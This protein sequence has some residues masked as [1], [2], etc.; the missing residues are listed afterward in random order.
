MSIRESLQ[1]D[2]IRDTL[3]VGFG[4]LVLCLVGA[5]AIGWIAV[6]AGSRDV[7]DELESV[8]SASQQTS[9]YATI[10]TR[11]IQAASSYLANHDSTSLRD[12]QH[13]GLEAHRLQR[14][15]DSEQKSSPAELAAIA[16]VDNR[17]S[18][19]EN[20]YALAHRLNDLGRKDEARVQAERARVI[21]AHLLDDLARFDAAKTTEVANT[22]AHLDY[23]AR[24]RATAVLG[25]AAIAAL[26]ALFIAMRAT[27]AIER[28]L[29]S[30]T[31]HARRLS[32]GDLTIRSHSDGLPGEFETLAAA[33]NHAAESL[34]RFVDVATRTADDVTHSASDLA[35]A[36]QQI[37][38]TANQVSEAVTQV[39]AGAEA[40]V[41]Q[42]HMVTSSLDT[43]RDGADGV[44][45]GAEEVQALAAAIQGQAADKR[46]ELVR[47]LSILIDVRSIVR[48]AADEV[49]ALHGTVGDINKFVVSVGRIADQTNLLSLNAAIE[50]AR[51]GAAGRGFG[52][53]AE[54]IRKLADQSRS[55]ADDVVNLTSS[56][57][58]RVAK[59][60]ST[61]ERGENQVGE[62]ERVSREIDEALEAIATAAERTSRAAHVVA[63][64]ADE[65][66]R[67]VR[68]ATDSLSDV[69]RTG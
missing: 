61:I 34:A 37:S 1:L 21:V 58:S 18:D 53:V 68:G 28:P 15:F 31:D 60:F 2:S 38:D 29:G 36:S 51:A 12:F 5:G 57:T 6:R 14:R 39:S 54:E 35:S 41:Q 22:T 62:L 47:T 3:I 59:T 48:Q 46:A 4:A 44:A 20:T 23:L 45:A 33:M 56:V 11:E 25:A 69:A 49:R 32:E 9:G 26:L 65:N 19:F 16:A 8:L 7:T 10:I 24:W 43:I 17:L 42:I 67:V 66:V 63:R 64:T 30:L 27:R 55:A 13:L 50:A 52:V 40:Q